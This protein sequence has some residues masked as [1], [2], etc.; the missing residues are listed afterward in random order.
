MPEPHDFQR[1]LDYLKRL[2]AIDPAI[3]SGTGTGEGGLWWVKLIINIDRPMAWR[4]V[5]E[6][7]HVLNYVSLNERLPAIS[8]RIA[9]PIPE[10]RRAQFP[11]LGH[12]VIRPHLTPSDCAEWLEGRSPARRRPGTMEADED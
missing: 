2:P 11:V 8:C 10:R 12:R 5:Q 1:L 6:L 4:I 7:G 9:A 3:G